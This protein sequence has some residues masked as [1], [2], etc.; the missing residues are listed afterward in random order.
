MKVLI[1]HVP[2]CPNTGVLIGRLEQSLAETVAV[3][4][5]AADT[6]A[7]ETRV[8]RDERAAAKLG[9][10]GSPTLLIDGEDPFAVTGQPASLSCRLY[11]DE[12]GA[13]S[14]APSVGQLRTAL[15]TGG[16]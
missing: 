8:V 12:T 15:A 3:D 10:A 9:M 13:V 4:T 6:I 7:V 2:D 11:V 16:R 1:L 5:I 14:G